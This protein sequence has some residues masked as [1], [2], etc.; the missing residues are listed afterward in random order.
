VNS[1]TRDG[2]YDST[3]QSSLDRIG[4]LALEARATGASDGD[5]LRSLGCRLD[6]FD[7]LGVF[8]HVN[9]FLMKMLGSWVL[10]TV[11]IISLVAL[12]NQVAKTTENLWDWLT[13][14]LGGLLGIVAATAGVAGLGYLGYKMLLRD[15]NE[16]DSSIAAISTSALKGFLIG[17]LPGPFQGAL[18]A[19]AVEVGGVYGIGPGGAAPSTPTIVTRTAPAA[20][21]GAP[22]LSGGPSKDG[23]GELDADTIEAVADAMGVPSG[24]VFDMIAN[25]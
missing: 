24:Q 14:K 15:K 5:I 9:G 1:L 6:G 7:G 19:V 22:P 11:Q 17:L 21:G 12:L 16:H 10:V 3:G 4:Q 8:C 25:A 2:V 20:E 13:K 23:D 18:M